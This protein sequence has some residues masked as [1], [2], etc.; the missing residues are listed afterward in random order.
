V[1]AGPFRTD[2]PA[3]L[4]C[5][6]WSRFHTLLI[7]ALGTSVHYAHG[8]HSPTDGPRAVFGPT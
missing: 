2:I 8:T 7:A 4:D 5:L 6:S 1:K 3:R